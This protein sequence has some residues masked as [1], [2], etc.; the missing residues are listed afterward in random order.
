MTDLV[1]MNPPSDLT[2]VITYAELFLKSG[3]FADVRRVSEAAV[4]IL[5][6]R[7]L[8]I[9]PFSAMQLLHVIKGKVCMAAQLMSALATRSGYTI[10]TEE[11]TDAVATVAFYRGD[12]LLGRS[13][14]TAQDAA[15]AGTQNMGRFPRAMLH[16]RAVSQGVRAFAPDALSFPVYTPEEM[17]AEVDGE[18]NVLAL[19]SITEAE[20]AGV[21]EAQPVPEPLREAQPLA[22]PERPHITKPVGKSAPIEDRIAAG[23]KALAIPEAQQREMEEALGA[24]SEALL[25]QLQ[26]MAKAKRAAEA[27]NANAH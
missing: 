26:S 18:G 4:K 3:Y 2:P 8:G 21:I 7:E 14:F 20:A 23:Y 6:G 27:S 5:A 1:K 17:G 9:P 24:G 25:S 12:L 10:V 16:H 13:T 15:K 19:P 22:A 11:W